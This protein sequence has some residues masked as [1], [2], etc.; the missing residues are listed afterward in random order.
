MRPW[1]AAASLLLRH[2]H[3]WLALAHAQS[4]TPGGMPPPPGMSLTESAAM[5]FPQPVRVGDLIGR[6]V[7]RPVESQDVL[8][9]VRG[10]FAIVMAGSWSWWISEGFWASEL[11]RLP[12]LWTPWCWLGRTWKSLPTRRSNSG[13]SRHSHPPAPRTLQTT[14]LSKWASPNPRTDVSPVPRC[15]RTI[16]PEK[17][18]AVTLLGVRRK[19]TSQ[20]GFTTPHPLLSR[21]GRVLFSRER[22]DTV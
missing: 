11:A 7:L 16:G 6:E 18:E 5:R 19:K 2:A 12:F 15:H 17:A 9:R 21:P 20:L 14:R 1:P 22:K 8:G 13:N 4:T 10:S 3:C